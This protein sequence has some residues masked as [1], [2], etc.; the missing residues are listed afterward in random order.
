MPSWGVRLWAGAAVLLSVAGN[1][2]GQDRSRYTLFNPVPDDQLREL[3]TDRPDITESPFTVDAGHVQFESTIFGFTRSGR[4]VGG[5]VSESYEIGTTNIR[6]GLTN[7]IEAGLV[8]Q[9]YGV[10]RTH[11][12]PEGRVRQSGIG[13]LELRGKVNLWGNDTF[14][15]TGSAAALLPFVAF[16][17]DRRNGVSPEFAEGGLIVPLSLKLPDKF[18]LATNVGVVWTRADAADDYHAEY[19]ASASLSYE[20]T[21]KIGTYYEVAGRFNTGDPRGDAVVLGTGITYQ[22]GKNVQLDAGANFGVTSAADRFNPF[23]GIAVRF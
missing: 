13:G 16:P 10:V 18:E 1:A 11:G 12:G 21:E 4:D 15:K 3:T 14:D 20:W 22:L 9:P 17:T 8:W 19:L 23:V 6:I 7:D 5:A 2:A